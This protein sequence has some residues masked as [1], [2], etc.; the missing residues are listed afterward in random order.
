M[1]ITRPRKKNFTP[2][3]INAISEA[4]AKQSEPRSTKTYDPN[5]PVFDIPGQQK[6]LVYIPKLFLEDGVTYDTEKVKSKVFDGEVDAYKFTHDSYSAHACR[7]GRTFAMTRCLRGV[8][9]TDANGEL[10]RDENGN[11]MLDGTCP[12]CDAVN[13]CWDLVN[14]EFEA[15]V[16]QKGLDPTVPDARELYKSDYTEAKKSLAIEGGKQRHLFPIFVVDCKP[17]D[18][19]KPDTRKPNYVEKDG[20]KYVTGKLYWYL[21]SATNFAK[22]EK[23]LENRQEA[24]VTNLDN[25]LDSADLT[26]AEIEAR[27]EKGLA[28][29]PMSMA[30]QWFV[31]DYTGNSDNSQWNKME[32]AKDVSITCRS[33]QKALA[34][35]EGEIDRLAIGWT[36]TVAMDV[37]AEAALRDLSEMNDL[38][39]EFTKSVD[40][41]LAMHKMA[42]S[43]GISAVAGGAQAGSIGAI[44]SAMQAFGAAEASAPPQIEAGAADD[45]TGVPGD[46]GVE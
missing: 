15:A 44:D 41:R 19:S 6:V 25:A 18:D 30:G 45:L 34:P 43:N 14:F 40:D 24:D 11:V 4:S 21:A 20:K 26:D 7:S 17:G 12:A 10:C 3:Q 32:A 42:A 5:F 37:V 29:I 2:S 33:S 36:Q 31:L 8:E 9:L 27:R 22:W 39:A 13:K 38:V 23:A 28:A 16:R 46:I 1:A 35:S